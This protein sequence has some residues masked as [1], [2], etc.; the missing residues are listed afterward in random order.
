MIPVPKLSFL[1]LEKL[2]ELLIGRG[3]KAILGLQIA[4]N[5]IDS[6]RNLVRMKVLYEFD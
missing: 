5:I 6:K 4:K 3:N 2:I 1:E